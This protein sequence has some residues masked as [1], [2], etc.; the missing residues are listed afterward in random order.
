MLRAPFS[1]L[2]VCKRI[3]GAC[4]EASRKAWTYPATRLHAA[5]I[6]S[7]LPGLQSTERFAALLAPRGR[8][9]SE[10]KLAPTGAPEPPIALPAGLK[11]KPWRHQVAAYRFAM[12]RFTTGSPGVLLACEMGTG[13]SLMA[14][15]IL[16]A[17]RAMRVLIACPLRVIPVWMEQLEHHLSV[18]LVA[19]ALDEEVGSVTD[20]QRLAEEKLRLAEITGV[21]F[22][23]V[24]NYD[25]VWREPFGAWAERQAWDLV[26]ADESYKLKRPG[27]KASL[28]FKRL[29]NRARHRLAL[30]GTPMPHS[31]LDVYAQFRFLDPSIF[32][33]SF[34]AF[35]QKYGVMGGFQNKQVSAYKNLD[36]LE[37]LVRRLTFRVGKDVLELPPEVYVTYHC[38]LSPEA[39]RVYRD[40]EEDFM[41]EVREGRV[42]AANAM[43]KLLRLQQLTGGWVKTDDERYQR[44]D[45]AKQR[46]LEDTLEDIGTEE[47]VVVFCRFHA[48]LDAVHEACASLG[49]TC[50]ELSGRRAELTRWQAG[51]AQLLAV[52]ISSG[53]VGVDLSRARYAIYY[54]LSFSLGEYDQARS[55]VHRPGQARP[56]EHIH[57]VAKG[58]VDERIM[59]ALERR[60]EV[61]QAILAEIKG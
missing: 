41:A 24:I 39:R 48:D 7:W 42:S 1:Y 35:K 49:Y 57:L 27:G 19:V 16:L 31:P 53:G 47:P 23:A 2:L 55:R 6:V 33:P 4:W 54:S 44:L 5:R 17:L 38:G 52:Q 8:A 14:C 56:V 21:P 60:A 25:S 30:T 9:L 10:R 12:Q 13:K 20:K 3:P 15:M 43:V 32:G 28:Y 40:L 37:T 59:R 45:W 36:E 26:V 29:R 46:L 51:E 22:V 50:L 58:T 18:P 34:N 61:I 11:T